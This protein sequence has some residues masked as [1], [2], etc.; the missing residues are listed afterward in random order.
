MIQYELQIITNA[1]HMAKISVTVIVTSVLCNTLK[2]AETR[3][4]KYLYILNL[5]C[6]QTFDKTLL[7]QPLLPGLK[8]N[9]SVLLRTEIASFYHV[10]NFSIVTN[11]GIW[12][13]LT[14]FTPM[15]ALRI[16]LFLQ[17]FLKFHNSTT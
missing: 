12:F 11:I 16:R 5:R 1:H 2:F 8:I 14:G 3:T 13:I 15:P 7:A 6:L 9:H 4:V 17:V 10:I